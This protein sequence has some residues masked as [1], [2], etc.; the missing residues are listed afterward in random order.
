M[1]LK[2]LLF[3]HVIQYVP[4]TLAKKCGTFFFV[5]PCFLSARIFC[6]PVTLYS[7]KNPQYSDMAESNVLK[8]L[9][10]TINALL[11]KEKY[12]AA[13]AVLKGFRNGAV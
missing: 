5:N 6:A 10:Y 13:L 12:K 3:V 8:T 1:A 4:L 11:Q 2:Q 9:L 7:I